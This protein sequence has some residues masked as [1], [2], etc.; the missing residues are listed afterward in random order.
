MILL[1]SNDFFASKYINGVELR[2]A[3]RRQQ[4]G[5][6][7]IL[8]VLLEPSPAFAKQTWLKKL[9]TV[10]VVNGQLRLLSG[11][12]PAVTGW[13]EVQVALRAIISEVAGRRPK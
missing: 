11:F 10:P 5:E 4:T 3:K 2:E 8:P 1:L 7:E 13:N 9:K 6:A 12:N